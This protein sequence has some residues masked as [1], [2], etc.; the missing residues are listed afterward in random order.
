M[1]RRPRGWLCALVTAWLFIG[2]AAPGAQRSPTTLAARD[3]L[4]A[5]RLN[6]AGLEQ[7]ANGDLEEAA[8]QFNAAL[9]ADPY[10]GPAHCN[11]G[12]VQLQLGEFAEAGWSL[13]Y[14][15]RLMPRSSAPRANLGLLYE[16]VGRFG[17]AEAELRAALQLAPDDIEIIGHL[18]RL[19][20]R[21]DRWTD[22]SAAWLQQ[23][24]TRDD[25]AQWRRWARQQ[26]IYAETRSQT[27]GGE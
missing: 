6:L 12:L 17:P 22:E 19:Y 4:A 20:V 26:L 5:E 8:D 18:A 1:Y 15:C 3:P 9:A 13:Q 16:Y 23:V 25:D 11:L 2:C 24:A 21:Q 27:P 10:Y 14:A 7:V